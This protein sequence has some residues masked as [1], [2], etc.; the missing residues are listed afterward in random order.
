MSGAIELPRGST[1]DLPI[2]LTD[3]DD[4]IITFTGR[5]WFMVKASECEDDDDAII[6]K[7]ITIDNTDGT[8]Y[9][10]ILNLTLED[11][12][13]DLGNNYIYDFKTKVGT[14]WKPSTA[15]LFKITNTVRHGNPT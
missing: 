10:G 11:S 6:S 14:D 13:N 8:P 7:E 9:H 4:E 15:G 1:L 2:T 3:D 5:L 12:N